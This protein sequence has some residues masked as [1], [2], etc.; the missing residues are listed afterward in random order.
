M[1][2]RETSDSSSN[3]LRKLDVNCV[4]LNYA[5]KLRLS[6]SDEKLDMRLVEPKLPDVHNIKNVNE[7]MD[8]LKIDEEDMSD[9]EYG[10][11][12]ENIDK[13]P[14]GLKSP[15]SYF[16][17]V[18]TLLKRSRT[19]ENLSAL[20]MDSKAR[21]EIARKIFTKKSRS[22]ISKFQKIK[23]NLRHVKLN[24]SSFTK[25]N[26]PVDSFYL[27]TLKPKDSICDLF[28]IA[29]NSSAAPQNFIQ[30]AATTRQIEDIEL[31]MEYS[32][33]DEMEV[34][35]LDEAYLSD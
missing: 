28:D 4:D 11:N 18:P 16:K 3:F 26:L 35:Y 21:E 8:E 19:F 6:T 9:E 31:V 27:K 13:G 20:D 15:P 5:Y 23:Q 29:H 1:C 17:N 32:D 14:A 10:D 33:S 25:V 12:I 7:L 2:N 24:R 22:R 30:P 34:E